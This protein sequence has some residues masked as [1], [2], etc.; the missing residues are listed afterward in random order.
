[1]RFGPYGHEEELPVKTVS[2]FPLGTL[3]DTYTFSQR[4]RVNHLTVLQIDIL[5][6]SPDEFAPVGIRDKIYTLLDDNSRIPRQVWTDPDVPFAA[7]EMTLRYQ[8][9][10]QF[11]LSGGLKAISMT[12]EIKWHKPR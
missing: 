12:Y 10:E 6:R 11:N 2:I 7:G 5:I 9:E 4:E 8:D 3:P 1:M